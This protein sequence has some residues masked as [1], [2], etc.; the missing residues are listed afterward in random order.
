[1]GFV[2]EK[3][4]YVGLDLL[5]GDWSE[6]SAK[7]VLFFI[8]YLA[9][10]RAMMAQYYL[11]PS[12]EIISRGRIASRALRRRLVE[13]S[14]GLKDTIRTFLENYC[15]SVIKRN[16]DELKILVQQL[17]KEEADYIELLNRK[18]DL[19]EQI[20]SVRTTI[21][22]NKIAEDFE[23]ILR[24]EGVGTVDVDRAGDI[25]VKTKRIF[26]TPEINGGRDSA[27]DIGEFEIRIDPKATSRDGIHFLQERYRGLFRHGHAKQH[28]TCFGQNVLTGNLN[29]VM[30][31]HM[32]RFNILPLI[33]LCLDFLRKENTKPAP[34]VGGNPP[35]GGWKSDYISSPD[36]QYESPA[37]LQA[38]KEAFINAVQEALCWRQ[39]TNVRTNLVELEKGIESERK[40][41]NA[42]YMGQCELQKALEE[43]E[44]KFRR[45]D[46]SAA[47]EAEKLL[48]NRDIHWIQLDGGSL[49]FYFSDS[50]LFNALIIIDSEHP[51][52]LV[53]PFLPASYRNSRYTLEV[54]PS[55]TEK[56]VT[57][58]NSG[59]ISEL[60][61]YV[62][63]L[64]R[65]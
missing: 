46:K 47:A 18:F 49:H 39:T 23:I 64:M 25:I 33:M 10:P 15:K 51:L 28:N 24:L 63:N 17:D 44:N 19:E 42:L 38:A 27:F 32:A 1:M 22:R 55:V 20:Q 45:I 2:S 31:K 54:G 50:D 57:L 40:E 60:I 26:Q 11:V 5:R 37:A 52:R 65:Q 9:L 56:I 8:L 35:S 3:N 48:N 29:A 7:K 41:I 14:D 61:S 6:D 13:Q 30:D 4:I 21:D 62:K 12:N 36:N 16:S 58:Q 43:L 34:E 59:N 53:G